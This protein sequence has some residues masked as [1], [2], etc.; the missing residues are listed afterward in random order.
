[1]NYKFQGIVESYSTNNLDQ[2]IGGIES[3]EPIEFEFKA[4]SNT[5]AMASARIKAR[6]SLEDKK[7][8]STICGEVFYIPPPMSIGEVNV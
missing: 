4:E 2:V 5:S 7:P 3:Q 6:K 8:G 1:M